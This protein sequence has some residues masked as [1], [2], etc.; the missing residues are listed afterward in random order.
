MIV[1]KLKN[2]KQYAAINPHIQ[3]V[4]D[5]LDKTDVLSLPSGKH[6]IDGKNVWVM[7][8]S[9][10]PRSLDKCYFEGHE[11]YLD[12]QI[13]LKGFEYIG[14]HNIDNDGI[15]ITD[16]YN[17][18]KDV[19]KYQIK[20]FVKIYLNE[21]MF[22]L[23]LPQDLHMPKLATECASDVEKLVFKVKVEK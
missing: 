7:R 1:D 22:A 8:E 10:Q 5:Y 14:Y 15:A 11:N 23:V 18:E 16:A 3:T 9:Y 17:A 21:G 2:L 20:H 19:A 6:D 12:I 4:L 13:V